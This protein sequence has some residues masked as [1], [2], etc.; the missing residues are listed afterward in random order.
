MRPAARRLAALA[1]LLPAL[2]CARGGGS[3]GGPDEVLAS[4]SVE[5]GETADDL[6]ERQRRWAALGLASYDMDLAITCF[7]TEEYRRPV[8][9]HVRDGVA[10]GATA[11]E[12]GSVRPAAEYPTVDSLFTRAIAERERGG[13]V[14]GTFDREYGYPTFIEIGTL[15]N[16]AGTGYTISGIRRV[17]G[18]GR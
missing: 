15:A 10:T 1:L 11:R 14:R 4:A 6:R 2:A 12:P 16:D 5:G 7:C 9:L 18:Q 13:H 17:V 8:T 3:G